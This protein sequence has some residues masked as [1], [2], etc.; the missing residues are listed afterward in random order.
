MRPHP[1]DSLVKLAA[2][3]VAPIVL[4]ATLAGAAPP[5]AARIVDPAA[6]RAILDKTVEVR[7]DPDLSVL[8]PGEREALGHLLRAGTIL[9]N[10]YELANHRQAA[11]ASRRIGALARGGA[12]SARA[13]A[14]LHRLNGGV[15]ATT[16]E[17]DRR[18]IL[19]GIDSLAPGRNVYPWGVRKAEIDRWLEAHPE[20][21]ASILDTRTTVRRATAAALQADLQTLDRHP[22]LR[23]FHPALEPALRARLKKPNPAGFYAVPYAL[24]F[25]DSLLQVSNLLHRAA[26]AVERH[27]PEFAGYLRLRARD[28]LANDYEGGD[29]AWVTGRFGRLNA[30]LG[31]YETYDDE[32]Y[33]VKAFDSGSLMLRDVA[34]SDALLQA[35][36]GL[37]AIE[38]SLPYAP[39][40]KVRDQISV[41]IYD[42]IADYGQARGTNTASILPNDPRLVSRYGRT[43]LMRRNVLLHPVVVDNARASWEAALDPR[44]HAEFD[45]EGSFQRVLWHEIG[46]YLGPDRDPS[47]RPLDLALEESAGTYEEMKADLVSLFA[48]NS[49]RKTGYYDERAL[50]GV[51]AAGIGRVLLKNRP[52]RDQA[53]GT[54]QLMQMNWYL[55]RGLLAIDPASKRLRIDYGKYHDTVAALLKEVLEIQAK[56]DKAAAT[57]FIERWAVWDDRHEALARAMRATEKSRFRLVRYAALG[58]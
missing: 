54:M 47:G 42:V 44:H 41:G 13:L 1:P 5:P 35:L 57:R 43:I 37:Q 26:G 32:L 15:I 29:A 8:A 49:L 38:E 22:E 50:R 11:E 14:D 18:P 39:R 12:D 3:V 55:D 7:L 20:E 33:G 24:A 17:N 34:R 46:H 28:L 23:A 56:G 53:Y 25:A 51:Y 45:P 2:R 16:L 9:Q 4:A 21:R 6:R 30:Q 31:S 40:K 27:D 52:R 36:G 58:E 48:A 19:A 10:L